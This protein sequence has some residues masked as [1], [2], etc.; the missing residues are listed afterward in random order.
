M[1]NVHKKPL[2]KLVF[3]LSFI[4]SIYRDESNGW[5]I[6]VLGFLVSRGSGETLWAIKTKEKLWI[7]IN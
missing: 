6:R 3:V 7:L 1:I 4:P 2:L 5:E